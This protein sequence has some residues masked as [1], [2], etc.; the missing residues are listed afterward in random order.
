[1]P[2]RLLNNI[3]PRHIS[4]PVV[5]QGNSAYQAS[6]EAGSGGRATNEDQVSLLR[7]PLLPPMNVLQPH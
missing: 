6:Q 3:D 4:V 1:M 7:E 2:Q 5:K